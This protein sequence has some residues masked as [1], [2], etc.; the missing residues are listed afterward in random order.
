MEE[1]IQQQYDKLWKLS[2]VNIKHVVS[3]RH[4]PSKHAETRFVLEKPSRK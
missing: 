3:K 4:M 1:D 2:Q